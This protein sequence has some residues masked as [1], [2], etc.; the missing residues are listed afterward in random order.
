METSQPT[1]HPS[2][3][4]LIHPSI[5]ASNH[6]FIHSPIHPPSSLEGRLILYVVHAAQTSM[7]NT[8]TMQQFM[9]RPNLLQIATF[10][11]AGMKRLQTVD[12]DEGS[13]I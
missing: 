9:S 10:L 5:H 4:S 13:N 1:I 3:H 7:S 8:Q 2:T 11:E 12:P 6:P